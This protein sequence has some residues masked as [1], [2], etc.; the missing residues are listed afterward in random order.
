VQSNSNSHAQLIPTFIT[1]VVILLIGTWV[2]LVSTHQGQALTTEAL[3]QAEIS[4]HPKKIQNFE[5]I[6]TQHRSI[7]WYSR[8]NREP[9]VMIVDF[10]Y[11]R[12]QTVCLALGSSFQNLQEQI[13]QQGLEKKVGLIS[14]SFDP[15][16]DDADAL[17]RYA[18]RMKMNPKI[19]QV[20]S[21]RNPQDRQQL[22]DA[23][24]I[25]V[26]A[27]PLDEFEHNAAFHLVYGK[28]LY[29]IVDFSQPQEAL[30][31]AKFLHEQR[32]PS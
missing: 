17:Q 18:Q 23:F 31:A 25:M 4:E 30:D 9:R 21:L 12:C 32:D 28:H 20:Y 6:D 15:L 26:I 11:T 10:V 7:N 22:L 19:W 14:I 3:R 2:F 24:G 29:R 16:H 8:F 13:E 5:L 1:S 27:A